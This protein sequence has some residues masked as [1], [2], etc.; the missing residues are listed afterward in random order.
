VGILKIA[1]RSDNGM[2]RSQS[3]FMNFTLPYPYMTTGDYSDYGR[4]FRRDTINIAA[5]TPVNAKAEGA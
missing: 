4:F 2:I 5:P 3:I 1:G